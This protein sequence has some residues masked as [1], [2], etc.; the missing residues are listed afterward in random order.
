MTETVQHGVRLAGKGVRLRE[1]RLDDLD[2]TDTILSDDRVT[3]WLSFDSKTREQ[4][5]DALTG[6][7]ER[8][9][10]T[11]NAEYYLAVITHTDDR[12]IGSVRL[13]LRDCCV[14]VWHVG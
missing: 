11:P 5:A 13:G 3:R 1:F 4:Q 7:I 6:A 10:Q 8:A 14:T 2:D 12:L 9:Q